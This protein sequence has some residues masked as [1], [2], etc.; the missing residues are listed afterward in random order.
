MLQILMVIML[1]NSAVLLHQGTAEGVATV[2]SITVIKLNLLTVPRYMHRCFSH[3]I[4]YLTG[5]EV[6][7]TAWCYSLFFMQ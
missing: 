2:Y 1:V 3:S 6:K 7:S 5:I 4:K